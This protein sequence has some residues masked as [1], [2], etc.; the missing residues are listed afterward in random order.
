MKTL[1]RATPAAVKPA[2]A[3]R[4]SETAKHNKKPVA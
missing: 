4:I 1:P 3:C 2:A